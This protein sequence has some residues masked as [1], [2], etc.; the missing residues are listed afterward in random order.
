[1]AWSRRQRPAEKQR[2]SS[3]RTSRHSRETFSVAEIN[4]LRECFSVLSCFLW[5]G[6]T[7]LASCRRHRRPNDVSREPEGLQL[8]DGRSQ[9]QP[10]ERLR[11]RAG[12][13]NTSATNS[14]CEVYIPLLTQTLH[15]LPSQPI[16]T[17]A[18]TGAKPSHYVRT[19]LSNP[20]PTPALTHPTHTATTPQPAPP[21]AHLSPASVTSV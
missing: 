10:C 15:P 12:H 7:S 17:S 4:A 20:P 5:C 2:C 11:G 14:D 3:G 16:S 21:P 1:M 9:C 6:L 8:S 19:T 13:V 18:C